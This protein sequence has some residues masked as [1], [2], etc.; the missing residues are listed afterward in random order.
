IQSQNSLTASMLTRVRILDQINAARFGPV[1]I[2]PIQ[3]ASG[4]V[5]A[6][7]FVGGIVAVGLLG[8]PVFSTGTGIFDGTF[9][10]P[11]GLI[12]NG[13]GSMAVDNPV[14][15]LTREIIESAL[16]NGNFAKTIPV[17]NTTIVLIVPKPGVVLI[18]FTAGDIRSNGTLIEER[19][20]Y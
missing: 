4:S 15:V 11:L 5:N 13:I 3:S 6:I 18:G 9:D 8:I 1:Y 2:D 20:A 16:N 12:P 17:P 19:G 10:R 7:D 14:V